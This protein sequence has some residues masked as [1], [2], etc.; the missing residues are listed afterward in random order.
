MNI[1]ATLQPMVSVKARVVAAIA[2]VGVVAFVSMG[3]RDASHVAVQSAAATIKQGPAV[4]H[5]TLAP[6]Q[7]VAR[8]APADGKKT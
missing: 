5:I 1:N 3:A 8:R 2:V 4:T 6:V 7:I